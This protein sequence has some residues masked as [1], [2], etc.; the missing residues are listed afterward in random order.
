MAK[1]AGSITVYP[2]RALCLWYVGLILIGTILLTRPF[3]A[4]SAK[5]PITWRE[6]CFTATSAACVTGLSVRSTGNDFSLFGQAVIL[7]LIQLGGIG[8]MTVATFVTL[9]WTGRESLHQRAAL[10]ETLGANRHEDL[11][12][13]LKSVVG[14]TLFFEGIGFGI[15]MLRF[16]LEMDPFDAIW[17]ALFHSVAAFCNAGFALADNNLTKYQGDP[18]VNLTIIFLIIVGGIG[19]PVLL[20]FRRNGHKPFLDGWQ[21]LTLHS[22]LTV[23][24]TVGLVSLGT[25]ALLVLESENLFAHMP[26]GR[27]LLVALF[28]SVSARTAGFNTVDLAYMSNAGLFVLVLLMSVGAGACSTGGG[29]KVSTMMVLAA[30]AWSRL[31]GKRQVLAFRRSISPVTVERSIAA[32]LLFIFI[33][34]IA[35]TMMLLFESGR[36]PHAQAKWLFL[37]ALFEVVSAL[38][39]TGLS[40]GFT[41]VVNVPGSLLL[42]GLMFVGRIGPISTVVVLSRQTRPSHLTFPADEVLIG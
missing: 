14:F 2:A 20:D 22:K 18:V 31:R 12:T 10:A 34:T 7:L 1:F 25:V 42:I 35:M 30:H 26:F 39:T 28:H 9:F 38:S 5:A 24:G 8:I 19:Y 3:C 41:T 13:V 29:F 23:L 40:V 11:A 32:V 21:S 16:L 37:D 6:G 15:L 17:N 33:G 36:V 4:N 27:R